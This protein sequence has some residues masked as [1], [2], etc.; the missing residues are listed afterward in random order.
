MPNI[1][2][3]KCQYLIPSSTLKR[4][5]PQPC[6]VCDS[7]LTFKYD[8]EGK[9]I[10]DKETY[11]TA[12]SEMNGINM[13]PY[14]LFLTSN[15]F[16][17]TNP[18]DSVYYNSFPTIEKAEEFAKFHKQEKFAIIDVRSKQLNYFSVIIGRVSKE[19]TVSVFK[20][21]ED[22]EEIQTEYFNKLSN[23][24]YNEHR[25]YIFNKST[26]EILDENLIVFDYSR[27]WTY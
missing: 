17:F 23:L 21:S 14:I 11:K 10:F 19:I 16:N 18:L 8:S 24:V 27:K 26:G 13:H 7:V 15:K 4:I 22:V 2:C 1:H 5:E 12:N 9:V 6:P 25:L 20:S 3:L